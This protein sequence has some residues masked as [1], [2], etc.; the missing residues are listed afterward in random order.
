MLEYAH[1]IQSEQNH[2]YFCCSS[3]RIHFWN[4]GCY[5]FKTCPNAQPGESQVRLNHTRWQAQSFRVKQQEKYRHPWQ[6][7]KHGRSRKRK[8]TKAEQPLQLVGRKVK[9]KLIN[10]E[11]CNQFKKNSWLPTALSQLKCKPNA[12]MSHHKPPDWQESGRIRLSLSWSCSRNT[13]HSRLTQDQWETCVWLK[14]NQHRFCLRRIAAH[15]ETSKSQHIAQ[16]SAYDC[17]NKKLV[18]HEHK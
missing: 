12:C 8:R 5:S 3:I 7:R 6:D 10:K 1:Q 13:W 15:L 4:R 16:V 11:T 14:T 18:L 2:N 17:A 9:L